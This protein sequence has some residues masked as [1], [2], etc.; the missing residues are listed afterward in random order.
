MVPFHAIK[1]NIHII[2]M[3]PFHIGIRLFDHRGDA[4]KL[5]Y[6]LQIVQSYYAVAPTRNHFRGRPARVAGVH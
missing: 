2:F 1:T 4:P 3:R 6:S 5:A